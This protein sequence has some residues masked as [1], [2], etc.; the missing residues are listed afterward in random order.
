MSIIYYSS[1]TQRLEKGKG[2]QYLDLCRFDLDPTLKEWVDIL[3]NNC[4]VAES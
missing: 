1:L 3:G 2:L 4:F